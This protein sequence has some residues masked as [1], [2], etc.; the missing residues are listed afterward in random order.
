MATTGFSGGVAIS[1]LA[2]NANDL[3]FRALLIVNENA[4][5]V[6]VSVALFNFVCNCGDQQLTRF[7]YDPASPPTD[8]ELIRPSGSY[9]GNGAP[10]VDTLPAGGVA[11]W[12]TV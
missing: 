8:D 7:L 2:G 9:D 6:N 12:A 1:A 11:V 3:A 5:P 4:G 10:L